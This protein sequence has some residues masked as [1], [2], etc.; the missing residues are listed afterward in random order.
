MKTI[1][2]NDNFLYDNNTNFAL[3]PIAEEPVDS[4]ERSPILVPYKWSRRIDEKANSVFYVSPS[5]HI[6]TSIQHALG[7]LRNPNTCKCFLNCSVDLH[8]VF[9]FDPDIA[10]IQTME[11]HGQS[12]IISCITWD[13]SL[14]ARERY[15]GQLQSLDYLMS[16]LV[17]DVLQVY[18]S[19]HNV[20]QTA[21]D[22][23]HFNQWLKSF[24]WSKILLLD[25]NLMYMG[26][27]DMD[28]LHQTRELAIAGK[29]D[30]FAKDSTK[31]FT[32]LITLLQITSHFTFTFHQCS[33]AELVIPFSKLTID[34]SDKNVVYSNDY[35]HYKVPISW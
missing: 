6:I 7:Y 32:F 4:Q 12:T 35:G 5:G 33:I 23:D 28:L 22:D 21:R 15:I 34:S 19:L 2:V 1:S 24:E 11:W 18:N 31:V 3:F 27:P 25:G 13:N 9:N 14:T 10:T 29:L 8:Q 17:Q 16:N 20:S 30:Y 26:S